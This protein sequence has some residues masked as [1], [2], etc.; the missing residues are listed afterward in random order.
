MKKITFFTTLLLSVSFLSFAQ[1]L[2]DFSYTGSTQEWIVP[3][4]VTEIQVDA[5]GA[6]GVCL[7]IPV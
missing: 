3:C 1:S 2:V 6:S 7:D 5:Y 4:G